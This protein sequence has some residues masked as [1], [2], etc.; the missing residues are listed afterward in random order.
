VRIGRDRGRPVESELADL[1]TI[2]AHPS[3]ILRAREDPERQA[4]MQQFVDD[5]HTV[6]NWLPRRH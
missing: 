1:V 3:S 2:T 5:L 4:A 6:T